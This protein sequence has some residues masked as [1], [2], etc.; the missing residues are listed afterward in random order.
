MSDPITADLPGD[1]DRILFHTG[2]PD[3]VLHRW[4][5]RLAAVSPRGWNAVKP[6]A[7]NIMTLIAA[8]RVL[9]RAAQEL[10]ARGPKAPGP[11]G[12]RL[13]ALCDDELWEMSTVLG[14]ALATDQYRPGGERVV[15]VE[16]ASGTGKRPLVLMDV[17]DR[18]VQ[19]A[20][21]L[22]L[23]PLL[24]PL[25]D[26]LSFAYRR[27]RNRQQAV[28][29]AE[30]LA[31]G[32]PIWLTHDLKDAYGRVPVPRLLDVVYELLPCP[33]LRDLLGRVLPPQS[34]TLTGI[35]QG[36]P[37]SAL[38]L[39]LYLT[40]F[41]HVPWRKAGHP[42]RVIRYADDL[43]LAAANEESAK[44]ADSALRDL[45]TP[46]GMLLKHTFEE[47]RRDI[48]D[49]RAEWL[50]YG[51]RLRDSK[52]RVRVGAHAFEKLGRRFLLAHGKSRS[53]ERA[54]QILKQWV[55]QLGPCYRWEKHE[56][57]CTKA[58]QTAH[59]YGFEETPPVAELVERWERANTRWEE[60]REAVRRTSGYLA[61]GPLEY[62]MTTSV[63]W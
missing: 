22:V 16:K 8:P 3:A 34:P 28:A 2:G 51:F 14:R 19:K 49:H 50:G 25:F 36:G 12:L 54:V 55:A 10:R 9:H 7:T 31:T 11:N 26:P 40:H 62:P 38:G 30:Q 53:V 18:V 46:A 15:W 27:S 29:V 1:V 13:E 23:R 63:V 33:R 20:A 4:R 59:A 47:A 60:T 35:K 48:R 6:C 61:T 45:L 57:V 37:F 17:Q 42:T 56:K 24:D 41:L 43:L 5:E 44:A 21:A 39:E 58:I 32:H 52:L